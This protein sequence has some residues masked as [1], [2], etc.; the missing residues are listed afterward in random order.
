[1]FLLFMKN[2]YKDPRLTVPEELVFLTN[3]ANETERKFLPSRDNCVLV[4]SMLNHVLK[5]LGYNSRT[6]RITA[7]AFP[8]DR[9]RGGG[10]LGSQ[11]DGRRMPAAGPGMWHGH[12]GVLVDEK[13]LLDPTFDQLKGMMPMAIELESTNPSNATQF[14]ID[15]T[16]IRL[17]LYHKQVG[18]K[19]AGDARPCRWMFMYGEMLSDP[20]LTK[21][22]LNI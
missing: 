3:L 12:L 4:S 11:G 13:W 2:S 9:R 16:F 10:V 17:N 15:G 8:K 18:F 20:R 7:A 19:D 5:T 14:E 22:F 1:M 21:R 6:V